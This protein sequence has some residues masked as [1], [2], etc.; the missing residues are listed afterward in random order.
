MGEALIFLGVLVFSA[1]LFSMMFSRKKIPDVLLLLLIGVL[2]GPV[3]GLVKPS[4]FGA[5]G[6]VFTSITLVVILFE[7]GT[8]ISIGDLKESW[9]STL[10]LSAS[11]FIGAALIVTAICMIRQKRRLFWNRP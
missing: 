11:G 10:K 9:S 1:H 8:G 4:D 7:G 2:I 3:L 6:S 5:I